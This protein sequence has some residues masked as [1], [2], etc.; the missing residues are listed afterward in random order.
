MLLPGER[1]I[2]HQE[3]E[4]REKEKFAQ[5]IAR[6]KMTSSGVYEIEMAKIRKMVGL[7]PMPTA[8]DGSKYKS[9]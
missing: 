7:P 5:Q 6:Y 1:A 9:I 2:S 3:W 4:R 8:E